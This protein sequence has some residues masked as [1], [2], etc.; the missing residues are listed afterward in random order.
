MSEVP[1]PIPNNDLRDV[2]QGL[3]KQQVRLGANFNT[4][5]GALVNECVLRRDER[6]SDP[7][8][9]PATH[10]IQELKQKYPKLFDI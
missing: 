2:V 10:A 6:V 4:C 1:K 5:L 7:N 9:A 3:S 8:Y